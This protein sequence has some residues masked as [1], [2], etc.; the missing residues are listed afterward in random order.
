MAIE[1]LDNWELV[2]KGSELEDGRYR[3]EDWQKSC[4]LVREI[5]TDS[6][7]TVVFGVKDQEYIR[8]DNLIAPY[9]HTEYNRNRMRFSLMENG[10]WDK[11]RLR[12]SNTSPNRNTNQ[13]LSRRQAN[14]PQRHT[15]P[16]RLR[17]QPSNQLILNCTERQARL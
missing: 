14:L 9:Y 7:T 13:R 6:P 16:Q 10:R 4:A 3:L 8:I 2:I 1:K 5:G 17:R 15:L 11:H 12:A